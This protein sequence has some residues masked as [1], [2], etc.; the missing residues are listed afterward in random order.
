MATAGRSGHRQTPTQARAARRARRKTRRRLWRYGGGGAIGIIAFTFIIALFLPTIPG[1]L[2]SSGGGLFGGN[3][4]GPGER[5]AD[6]VP[7]HVGIDEPH[8]VYNSVPATSGWHYG[9]PLSPVRWGIHSEFLADEYRL[10]NLEH[11]GIGIH[12][13]CPAGCIETV[14]QLT[15]LAPRGFS[16]FIISPYTQMGSKI[17]ITAWRHI[18]YL[19][20]FDEVQLSEFID[21]YLD[22]AP[23]SVPGNLF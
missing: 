1:G 22:R 12:Y 10:H 17:A 18:L 6:Q 5:I 3:P 21:E 8:P 7:T 15:D 20:E 14:Q 2:G 13:N 9:Q 19:D 4:S 23:E 16:Q 11:G